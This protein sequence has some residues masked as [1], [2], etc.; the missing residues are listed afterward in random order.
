M[1]KIITSV[2]TMQLVERGLIGLDDNV[3][4]H[5]PYLASVKVIRGFNDDG[6]AILEPHTKPIT[7]RYVVLSAL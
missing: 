3:G 4:E 2:C 5:Q 1:A 6:S 7:L